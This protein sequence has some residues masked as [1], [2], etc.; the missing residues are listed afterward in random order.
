MGVFW[1]L[2]FLSQ[3]A[4]SCDGEINELRDHQTDLSQ[5][6]E[7]RQ[8]NVQQLQGEADTLDSDV[9]NMVELK[10]KV[11]LFILTCCNEKHIHS[12]TLMNAFNNEK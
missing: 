12:I 2:F 3:E 5:Q 6:L 8:I 10:Q 4:N 1:K 11:E 9:E 7:Q